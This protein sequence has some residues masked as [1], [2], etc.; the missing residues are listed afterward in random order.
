MIR[1][2]I[3]QARRAQL[4]RRHL[5]QGAGIGAGALAL[6]AVVCRLALHVRKLDGVAL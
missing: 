5:L 6:A 4:S 1:Q 3:A 2:L